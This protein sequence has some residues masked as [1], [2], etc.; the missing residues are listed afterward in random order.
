MSDFLIDFRE[1]GRR[2]FSAA[3]HSL[4]YYEDIK[5]RVFDYEKFTLVLSRPDDWNIWGPFQTM[6]KKILVA[7]CGRIAMDG[8]EW[9]A[10][11]SYTG[12]IDGGL[13]CKAIY[14]KYRSGGI[15]CLEDLNGNYV[16][17]LFDGNTQRFYIIVDRCGMVPCF[18]AGVNG[19]EMVLSSHPDILAR[20]LA[21]DNDWDITS[22]AEFL[23]T[24]KVTFPY[25]YYKG[26]RALDF[27]CIHAFDL[28]GKKGIHATKKKYFDFN[29]MIDPSLNEWNLAEQLALAFKRAVNRRILLMFGQTAIALS[30]GLDSRAILC[31]AD[32]KKDIWTFCF[33]DEEN[34]EYRIAKDVA[35]EA[36][37][38]LIPL[39]REFDHYGDSAEMGV[40]ISG[41][42]GDFGS[43][44]F[45]G[46]RETL[47][48]L[49][50]SN[51]ITGFYCDYLF[52]GLVI[53]K[54][55]NR[56][57]R[58]E[59][60]STF[61][62]E[63]YMPLTWFDTPYSIQV[64]ERFEEVFPEDIRRDESELGKLRIEQK[65][66]F[67]LYSEPD[68]QETIIPQRVMGW[69]LPIIDNEI[70]A[71]Y[72]RIP[73]Q[74]KLNTSIYSKMVAMQCGK[75]M[76]KI[77]N[78]NTGARI[79]ASKLELILCRYKT[80]LR[81]RLMSDKKSIATDESW[82]NW[83]YYVYNSRKIESL[84]MRDSKI[85]GDIFRQIT[86]RNPFQ[87]KISEYK[88]SELKLFLRLLTL[89]LWIEQRG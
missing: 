48:N 13:A 27:G 63:T 47:R 89:K 30:G 71:T 31:A 19:N 20:V 36:G 60:L 21:I 55:V 2:S 46:F 54:V 75:Q 50:I 58:T 49:G 9:E 5:V 6:D 37:V 82:P 11:K 74:Y 38:K 45:L 22:M 3:V 17:L 51:I 78:I 15:N 8:S 69:Y 25:S 1:K 61:R 62:Y 67:P 52:K 72:L 85:A 87:K 68:H 12:I 86:G 70:I 59:V 24:G 39:K 43:N 7:L 40:R 81:R 33:F 88:G 83:D 56:F 84:W 57:S 76:S 28:G 29:F 35:K 64:Q 23:I 65:R 34:L 26:I 73:P 77:M 80:A 44:H 53:D 79:D 42:M 16:V 10:A 41:G 14:E 18:G 4:Q 66:L 32:D